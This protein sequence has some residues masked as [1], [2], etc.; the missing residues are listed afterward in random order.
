MKIEDLHSTLEAHE[1]KVAKREAEKQDKQV[2]LAKL[3]VAYIL[4]T[5]PTKRLMGKFLSEALSR[6]KPNINH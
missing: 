1:M 2:L 5:C 3:S 4:N 6:R